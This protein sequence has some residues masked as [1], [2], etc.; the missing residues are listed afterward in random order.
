[1]MFWISYGL[2]FVADGDYSGPPS[3]PSEQRAR[4]G[5]ARSPSRAELYAIV[6]S[7][8]AT[9]HPASSEE[10][11]RCQRVTSISLLTTRGRVTIGSVDPVDLTLW[12][13]RPGW[14]RI[15]IGQRMTESPEGSDPDAV[16]L[17]YLVEVAACEQ[18]SARFEESV[19]LPGPF[20]EETVLM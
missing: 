18:P 14:V 4:Q 8:P 13:G 9:L 12:V 19:A 10:I 3:M 15:T 1:M 2:F 16:E 5:F 20:D 6:D 7:A 11:A 17:L